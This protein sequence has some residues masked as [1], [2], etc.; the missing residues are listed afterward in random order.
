MSKRLLIRSIVPLT[1]LAGLAGCGQTGGDSPVQP[2]QIIGGATK[3]I[4]DVQPVAGFLPN[5]SLLQPGGAGRAALVY[6][7][8]TANFASYNKILLDPVT[9]WT[10]PDSQ[11]NTVPQ[12]QRQAAADRFHADL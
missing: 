8:P 3:Q 5:A 7:N 6:R 2:G 9:I 4:T 10:A 11:L 12:N 1:I